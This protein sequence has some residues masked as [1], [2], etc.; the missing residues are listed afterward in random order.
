MVYKNEE[1]DKIQEVKNRLDMQMSEIE[2][3]YSG[4]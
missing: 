2:H 3:M 4:R 1:L